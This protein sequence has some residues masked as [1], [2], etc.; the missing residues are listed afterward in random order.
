MKPA[1]K[2][3]ESG[4]GRSQLSRLVNDPKVRGLVAQALVGGLL[5]FAG[6]YLVNQ[7]IY[8]MEKRGLTA[9]FDFLSTTAG[10]DIGYHM[11]DFSPTDT[12][13]TVF[14]VGIINTLFVSI[15]AIVFATMLG[16]VMGIARLS[17]NWLISRIAAT[18]V[19]VLRNTPLLLQIL[20]WYTGVFT[21][22]PPPKQS[23]E[24]GFGAAIIN[25]RAFQTAAPIAGDL[26]WATGLA[27][28]AGLAATIF[29]ARKAKRQR[30]RTGDAPAWGWKAVGLIVVLPLAVYL[31]TGAPLDWEVPVLKGFNYRGGYA[32]PP[33]FLALLLALSIYTSSFIAEI[34]R[35]GIQ[36]VGKGQTEAAFSLGL[37]PG[38]TMRM[39]VIPQAMRAIIPPLISQYLNIVKNSSLGVAI[40]YP[41]LV[42]V[43]M[44]TSLNQAGRAI[45]IVAT[46]MLFYMSVSLLISGLLNIY[47]RRVQMTE[48]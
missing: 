23:I 9:G 6:F 5:I 40:A 8:N 13:G 24:I 3:V 25:N 45:E 27:L 44:Q 22:L 37:P 11:I 35:A 20:V 48:R 36:S 10:F 31:A 16:F 38:R 39:V 4:R 47:N 14:L 30:Q 41:D 19:E 42:A 29:I 43:W 46:T 15:I 33:P 1:A 28:L 34:V 2:A 17:K 7:T 18:Y 21:L 26:L 12:F 32:L